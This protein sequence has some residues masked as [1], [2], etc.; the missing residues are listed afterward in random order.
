MGH[1]CSI[2]VEPAVKKDVGQDKLDEDK[3]H[4]E[5]FTPNKAKEVD[6]VLVVNIPTKELNQGLLFFFLVFYNP[7]SCTLAKKLHEAALHHEPEEA[8]QVEQPRPHDQVQ[9]HPLVVGVVHNGGSVLVPFFMG[10]SGQIL[11]KVLYS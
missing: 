4:I 10:D 6:A 11:E 8:R 9:R 7:G 1:L 2:V 5:H 3:E